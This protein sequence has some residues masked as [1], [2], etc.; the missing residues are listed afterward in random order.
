[1]RS[2]R[3]RVFVTVAVVLA[4]ATAAS[5]LLSRRATLV[6]EQLLHVAVPR[7]LPADTLPAAVQQAFDSGGWPRVVDVLGARKDRLIA[8]D[9]GG[10]VVAGSDAA[11]RGA[12]VRSTQADGTLDLL[13]HDDDTLT[14]VQL[15]GVPT[16][17]VRDAASQ[18][19]GRVF[20]LPP[21]EGPRT[22]PSPPLVPGWLAATIGTAIVALLL[23]FVLSRRILDPVTEL[24][25]AARRMRAGDL[26][27][28][29]RPVGDDEIAR[30]GR[31]FN[32][33]ADRLA[34]DERVKR[35]MV[36]D[37]AHELRSPVTNLRCGLE[38]IQDGLAP[39]DTARIDALHSETL[40]LQRLIG[41][42][43]DL[44]LA[45]AGGLALQID[46]VDVE[47]VARRAI[48][49]AAGPRVDL[50]VDPGAASVRADAGRLEQML[51]N[52]LS[53]ARRHTPADGRID[54][55]AVRDGRVVRLS[56]AD[57][58]A[59]IA[60]EHLPHVFDRFYRVD[61]SRDRS[62][63]GAGLGLAI[64]RRLAE[65]QGGTASASS[66]G[67]GRGATFTLEL[68][69]SDLDVRIE[70]RDQTPSRRASYL[71][72]LIALAIAGGGTGTASGQ[73]SPAGTDLAAF[74][75]S[76]HTRASALEQTAGMR[77]GYSAF[78]TAYHLS[79][80]TV[81]YGDYVLVRLLFEATRD[82]GFWNLHWTITNRDPNSD[83][84]WQQ[85]RDVRAPA[86]AA[87]TA[88]AECDELSALYAFLAAR[89]GVRRVGLFW[90]YA[91]HTVAVWTVGPAGPS[92]TRVVIPT[93]QI[94]LT[95]ADT[96][97]TRRFDPWTQK[98]IYPYARRDVP[99]T[100][101]IP[102]ALAAFFLA[103]VDKYAGASDAVLQDLR[104]LRES[105]FLGQRSPAAA[106]QEALARRAGL[107]PASA[108]DAAAY[109][110]FAADI[111][112]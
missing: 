24:T 68:P 20:V 105:V 65:A 29:V 45:D 112:R 51:R 4:A 49:D 13:L 53:N 55:R 64:V 41:D 90:P 9:R 2:L 33:M 30:L 1:M 16:F 84:V 108:E 62:T 23:T 100:F 71:A 59:G 46:T 61:S 106:A 110:H 22:R 85:W 96:F 88:S 103:Q 15:K 42:L 66:D 78:T 56:V 36:S 73:A 38:S 89:A 92:E 94:F 104:Y 5:G 72:G 6:E 25:D 80:S 43:Q 10:R 75:A 12:D 63:G 101:E 57:T 102:A 26:A 7:A 44:A 31:A 27:A 14:R 91:N 34:Q 111:R 82:A 97:G 18:D 3:T 35:Q 95:P 28:R 81:R 69:G 77:A 52:L 58:G 11:L 21:G 83:H 50:R 67:P 19:A 70:H 40:L 87:P 99:D 107:P 8:V 47:A 39:P 76:I 54:V 98:T 109:A 93:S 79:P 37:V 60:A 32:E 74:V 86:A 17:A 48:G